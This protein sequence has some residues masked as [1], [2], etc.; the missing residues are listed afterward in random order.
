MGE[1]RQWP[2]AEGPFVNA[3]EPP[4]I[5]SAAGPTPKLAINDRQRRRTGGNIER[6]KEKYQIVR[7]GEPNKLTDNGSLASQ[8]GFNRSKSRIISAIAVVPFAQNGQFVK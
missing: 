7:W 1:S 2:S 3:R 5:Q 6:G 4:L 8:E